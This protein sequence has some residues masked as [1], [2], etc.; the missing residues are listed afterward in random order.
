[1][2]VAFEQDERLDPILGPE[3]QGRAVAITGIRRDKPAVRRPLGAVHKGIKGLFQYE[4]V[5]LGVDDIHA[6]SRLELFGEPVEFEDRA[7]QQPV[8]AGGRPLQP[9]FRGETGK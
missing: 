8:V 5:L 1:M 7:D 9:G 6:G 2:D 3:D 4:R